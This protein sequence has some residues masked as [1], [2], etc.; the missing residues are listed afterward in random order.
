MQ[1]AGF[2]FISTGWLLEVQQSIHLFPKSVSVLNAANQE[3]SGI[4]PGSPLKTSPTLHLE[5]ETQQA[6]WCTFFDPSADDGAEI[7]WW[8]KGR[9]NESVIKVINQYE[10]L[11]DELIAKC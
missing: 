8:I 3:G 1:A 10:R 4:C 11:V 9:I 5:E 7:N 6:Q 2:C